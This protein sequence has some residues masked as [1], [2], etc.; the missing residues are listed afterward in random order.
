MFL[1]AVLNG[2]LCSFF[3]NLLSLIK[4]NNPAEQNNSSKAEGPS[5]IE[6]GRSLKYGLSWIS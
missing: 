1:Q 4:F 5:A 2:Y 6:G 3:N